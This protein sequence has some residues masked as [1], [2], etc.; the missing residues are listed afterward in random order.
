MIGSREEAG[1]GRAI[2]VGWRPKGRR[3]GGCSQYCSGTKIEIMA[4][5]DSCFLS[6]VFGL[7]ATLDL[8]PDYWSGTVSHD[9]IQ[10]TIH[11]KTSNA[12]KTDLLVRKLDQLTLIRDVSVCEAEKT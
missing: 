7:M 8:T 3:I 11:F 10:L 4:D 6:R 9:Q 2:G 1:T 5:T 12:K